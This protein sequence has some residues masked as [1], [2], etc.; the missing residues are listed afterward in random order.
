MAEIRRLLEGGRT[1]SFEFFPPRNAE[2]KERLDQT[3][4]DL[5]PLRPSFVS[6][7]YR[8]GRVSRELTTAAVMEIRKTSITPMPHLTCVCHTRAEL[9]EIIRNFLTQGFENL[10]ALGGDPVEGESG[11]LEYAEEL[12]EL[13]RSL[14][15]PSIGVAANTAGHPRSPDLASDRRRLAAKLRLADFAITQLFFHVADYQRLVEDLAALGVHKP[16]IPGIMPISTLASITRMAELSGYQVPADV[17]HR[18]RRVE[19]DPADVR[20]VGIEIAAELSAGVLEA[21]APGIHFYTLNRSTATREIYRD[22]GLA[23]PV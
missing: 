14:G 6:V 5:E 21:G 1:F 7:T 9:S 13:A 22:L 3:I 8:G 17:V 15:V 11:E 10:L 23:D 20:R 2:E 12:V 4:Q 16:V 18:V 19:H